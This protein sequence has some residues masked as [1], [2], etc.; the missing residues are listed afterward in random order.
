MSS[1]AGFLNPGISAHFLPKGRKMSSSCGVPTISAHF[2]THS[3]WKM[4]H[5]TYAPY[6]QRN[7]ENGR[8]DIIYYSFPVYIPHIPLLLAYNI[9]SIP[10]AIGYNA[11][12]KHDD[13]LYY[14]NPSY[15]QKLIDSYKKYIKM[16]DEAFWA[17]RDN[18]IR[19]GS[20]GV[21]QLTYF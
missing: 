6:G 19:G 8:T 5:K 9:I 17:S 18:Q 7:V 21:P 16:R 3:V 12:I 15:H 2:H 11:A 14:F 13:I 10:F 20:T 4:S 1:S